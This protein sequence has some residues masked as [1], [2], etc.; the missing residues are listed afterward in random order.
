MDVG[1]VAQQWWRAVELTES[2]AEDGA[3][4]DE[5]PLPADEGGAG[6]G[7][8]V[9]RWEAEEEQLD[10]IVNQNRRIRRWRRR[11]GGRRLGF[12]RLGK[13][14]GEESDCFCVFW[15]LQRRHIAIFDEP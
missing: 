2:T 5:V 10:E 6:E 8:G 13:R 11:R 15:S 9:I 1:D 3:G 12:V 4:D 7:R 14:R